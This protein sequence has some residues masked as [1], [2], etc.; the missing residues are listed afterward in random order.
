VFWLI[1]LGLV[2]LV[3]VQ[4]GLLMPMQAKLEEDLKQ[5]KIKP[6]ES[7]RVQRAGQVMA[8]MLTLGVAGSV[9][10]LGVAALCTLLLVLASRRATLRQV[11]ASL[12]EI[13]E[14]LRELKQAMERASAGERRGLSPPS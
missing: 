1:A 6:P 5:G 8:Q 11:S 10:M 3:F 9:G 14:Q 13:S 2:L 12:L 4:M 7:E